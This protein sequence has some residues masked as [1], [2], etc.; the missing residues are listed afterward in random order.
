ME[1]NLS[2][3][4]RMLQGTVREFAQ[5]ELAPNAGQWDKQG[6]YPRETILPKLAD[7][8]L[9][10][11]TM[12]EEYGGA[13][14]GTLAFSIMLEE[15]AQGDTAVALTLLIHTGVAS[16]SIWKLGSDELKAQVVPDLATG[17]RICAFAMTE[18]GGGTDAANM[19]TRAELDGNEYV[20]NGAKCF[21]SNGGFADVFT[22]L[23]KTDPSRKGQG[24]SAIMVE[25]G[26]PGFTVGR[27]EEFMGVRAA[28]ATELLFENA[29]APRNHLLAGHPDAWRR[30]LDIFNSER[31]GNSSICLGLA[32]AALDY[33][34]AY[35][36]ERP[37][38]G[39]TVGDFQGVKWMLADMAIEVEAARLMIRRAATMIDAGLPAQKETSMAKVMANDMAVRV[40][41]TALQLFGGYGYSR[42]YPMERLL[43]DARA[44]S[45]G[46]GTPQIQ[47]TMIGDLMLGRRQSATAMGQ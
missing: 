17:R 36:K 23:C 2:G 19:R 31:V 47:R 20:L 41:N 21:I 33:A 5:K 40:C 25:R 45:F 27:E 26:T 13:G 15:L 22:V 46:G 28:S 10:G 11:L 29:R 24:I 1:F 3:E 42:E 37:A 14:M 9:L 18:P 16:K 43:R 4:L 30:V 34:T 35:V 8:G 39:K 38:F 12:P 44:W 7:L 6:R 32:Q